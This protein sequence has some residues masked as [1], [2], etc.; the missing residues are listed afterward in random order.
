MDNEPV[1][2][3][4]HSPKK[5]RSHIMSDSANRAVC[6]IVVRKVNKV[7]LA[8]LDVDYL[9][10][11]LDLCKRCKDISTQL[12]LGWVNS[13]TEDDLEFTEGQ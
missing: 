12:Y 10:Q 11:N 4:V 9:V 2:H 7:D 1:L 6:G 3:V 5:R 13:L 8:R